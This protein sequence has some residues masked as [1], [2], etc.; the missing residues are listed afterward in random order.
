MRTLSAQT[1]Y[2]AFTETAGNEICVQLRQLIITAF[3]V[4]TIISMGVYAISLK[5]TL[6]KQQIRCSF[7]EVF[8][9]SVGFFPGHNSM[10]FSATVSP[11]VE[12]AYHTLRTSLEH[13]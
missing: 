6:I 5:R 13:R 1:I 11:A 2:L 3:V 10:V 7:S 4:S 9:M 12:V 8:Y